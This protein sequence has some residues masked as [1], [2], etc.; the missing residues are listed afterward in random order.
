MRLDKIICM[1]LACMLIVGAISV[2]VN[3]A[4]VTYTDPEKGTTQLAI[5]RASGSFSMRIP[6]KSKVLAN[7]SFPMEAGETVTINA[8][9]SPLDASMDFGLVD[10]DG[11]FHYFNTTS[12]SIDKTIRIKESG[13]Y[14]LQVRN[15]SSTEVKVS[16]FVKVNANVSFAD[17]DFDDISQVILYNCHNGRYSFID[18]RQSVLDICAFIKGL[19]GK[20]GESGKGYYEGTYSIQL[21]SENEEAVFEMVFGDDNVFYYG[22]GEDGYMRRFRLI[23]QT[24]KEIASFLAQYDMSG[25]E[26][27]KNSE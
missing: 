21:Q 2:P 27:G 17:S 25:F 24:S 8:S 5:S 13:N 16:G 3:A 9:Y 10:S 19:S 14:T 7:S 6:A 26:W 23:D 1:V 18:D 15:N 11:V 22:K 20:S 4:G 12:G